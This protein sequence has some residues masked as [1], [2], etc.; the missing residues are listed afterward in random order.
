MSQ[1]NTLSRSISVVIPAYN[2]ATSI[3]DVVRTAITQPLV[4]EVIV[5]N[6]GSNDMTASQAKHAGA[7]V[8]SH[9]TNKGKARAM[10][11]GVDAATCDH[12][13]FLDADTIGLKHDTLD[14]ICLPVLTHTYDMFVGVRGRN[15]HIANKFLKIA[16]L[17]GGERCMKKEVWNVVPSQYKKKFQIEIA[18]NYYAK[19]KSFRTGSAVINGLSQT[20][21]EQKW[22]LWY[23][24][25][26]R[27]AM[28]KDILWISFRLYIIRSVRDIFHQEIQKNVMQ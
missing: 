20:I 16:P 22:G 2:E 15:I 18:L 28:T 27:I 1:H 26:R 9:T 8:I 24:L 10:Q 25:Y 19:R 17:I 14:T 13:C 12:I 7:H 5:V 4:S 6:D 11:T 23:G 21:K 3:A